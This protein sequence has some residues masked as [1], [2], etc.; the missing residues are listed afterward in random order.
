MWH[1]E[2]TDPFPLLIRR[3]QG[4]DT[5][6][7]TPYILLFSMLPVRVKLLTRPINNDHQIIRGSGKR[8]GIPTR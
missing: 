7:G 6:P 8:S 5:L 2:L 1:S 3:L 4:S